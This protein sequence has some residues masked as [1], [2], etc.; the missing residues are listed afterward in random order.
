MITSSG[1][2]TNISLVDIIAL[3]VL[4]VILTALF[5]LWQ[6]YLERAQEQSTVKSKWSPPPLMKLSLWSRAHGKLSV[7]MI[8]A[9]LNWACFIAWNFWAQVRIPTSPSPVQSADQGRVAVLSRL[10]GSVPSANNG[11]VPT[12]VRDGHACERLRWPTRWPN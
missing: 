1:P 4:G 11:P 3:L 9:F 8:V 7:M 12:H 6:Y 2:S 10:P 5:L